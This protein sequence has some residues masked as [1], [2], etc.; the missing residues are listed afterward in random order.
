MF[1][2]SSM[3]R[4]NVLIL[5]NR[6]STILTSLLIAQFDEGEL[7]IDYAYGFSRA[8]G[9]SYFY[10]QGNSSTFLCK[11][12]KDENMNGTNMSSK[13]A[14]LYYVH[15]LMNTVSGWDTETLLQCYINGGRI[16]GN[17]NLQIRL[18]QRLLHLRPRK[19]WGQ[20]RYR[21]RFHKNHPSPR[22]S[23]GQRPHWDSL[24]PNK[25]QTWDLWADCR[26][27]QNESHLVPWCICQHAC[28][29]WCGMWSNG[30]FSPSLL[31]IHD[32]CQMKQ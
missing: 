3:K 15:Q 24:H 27:G 16:H 6:N 2:F 20:T 32:S 21:I 4:R 31:Y 23:F 11:V 28:S 17:L 10:K 5:C 30:D 7:L 9:K 29:N 12:N 22:D 1:K 8:T 18:A 14:F 13:Q 26:W 25:I 19:S